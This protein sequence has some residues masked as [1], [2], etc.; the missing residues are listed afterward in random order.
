ALVLDLAARHDFEVAQLCRGLRTAVHLHEADDDVHTAP[1]DVLR[2]VEHA[3]RLA[4]ARRRA[5]VHLELAALLLA[6]ELQELR[7]RAAR[8]LPRHAPAIS[9]F[10]RARIVRL[11]HAYASRIRTS[12][13]AR[14]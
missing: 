5:D 11:G 4:R 13:A 2:L 3:V 7:R 9:C 1:P 6:D 14:S 12:R 8:G 10:C